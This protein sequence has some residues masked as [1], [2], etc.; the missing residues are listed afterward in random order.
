M[1]SKK[2]LKQILIREREYYP[3]FKSLKRIFYAFL[4]HDRDFY[5]Y[6]YVK[7]LR[8]TEYYL[9]LK[10]W[11]GV[12]LLYYLPYIFYKN[13]KNKL[14]QKLGL[15]I[16]ENALGAGVYIA[17]TNII[18]GSAIVGKN[19]KMHGQNCIGSGVTIGNDCELWVG[20]KVFGNVTLGDNITVGA[21]AIVVSSFLE[22]G[23]TIAGVPARK[24]SK[25]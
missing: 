22:E 23:I 10:N 6:K 17:H 12:R 3:C 5:V 19:C 11:K 14:G 4:C 24:I 1:V 13:R 21:G 25:F 7:L 8:K 16:G 20:A 18:V 2:E 15:D 9:N